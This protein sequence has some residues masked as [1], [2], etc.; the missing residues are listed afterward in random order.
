[1]HPG[2]KPSAVSA[3]GRERCGVGIFGRR[4]SAFVRLGFLPSSA[5]LV[6]TSPDDWGRNHTARKRSE[7]VA[8]GVTPSRQL[9]PQH[10]AQSCTAGL[11]RKVFSPRMESVFSSC[12]GRS[13]RTVTFQWRTAGL[14]A[15]CDQFRRACSLLRGR[16][17]HR[18][19]SANRDRPHSRDPLQ[20]VRL[21]AGHLPLSRRAAAGDQLLGRVWS[22]DPG[23]PSDDRIR[24]PAIWW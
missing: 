12:G 5:R 19:E 18:S 6:W 15:G 10:R 14:C 1:M 21:C 8:R 2:E 24:S 23:V 13:E 7:A 9:S 4:R 11:R 16:A 20:G 22:R 3:S 17:G